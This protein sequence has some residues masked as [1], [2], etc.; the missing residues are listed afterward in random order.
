MLQE[1]V[2]LYLL[3]IDEKGKIPVTLEIVRDLAGYVQRICSHFGTR[4]PTDQP[5]AQNF[6]RDYK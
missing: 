3:A 2:R 1:L 4:L 6:V 5:P